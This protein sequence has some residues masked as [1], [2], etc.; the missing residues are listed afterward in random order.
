MT[1][2]HLTTIQKSE[3]DRASEGT[4]LRTDGPDA[5]L[6]L[7]ILLSACNGLPSTGEE[8]GQILTSRDEVSTES[9]SSIQGQRQGN[10]MSTPADGCPLREETSEAVTS[11]I[12]GE[13]LHH[14]TNRSEGSLPALPILRDVPGNRSS[15]DE[16]RPV[17]KAAGRALMSLPRPEREFAASQGA[18]V[19]TDGEQHYIIQRGKFTPRGPVLSPKQF[20]PTT[21][22]PPRAAQEA[23]TPAQRPREVKCLVF[24]DFIRSKS[25][26]LHQTEIPTLETR[27]PGQI[28]AS[29][30]EGREFQL[31]PMLQPSIFTSREGEAVR[32]V[33]PSIAVSEETI[34]SSQSARV[35]MAPTQ[36]ISDRAAKSESGDPLL[37]VEG[38]VRSARL[39][40]EEGQVSSV[41][42][43]QPQEGSRVEKSIDGSRVRGSDSRRTSVG[44][45]KVTS[46]EKNDSYGTLASR[47]P[48][49]PTSKQAASR[50]E[51]DTSTDKSTL[52]PRPS[53]EMLR[54]ERENE[55]TRSTDGAAWQTQEKKES[56]I[57]DQR[58]SRPI[59][60]RSSE[61]NVDAEIRHSG[62]DK[63][64]AVKEPDLRMK[65]GAERVSQLKLEI[66]PVTTANKQ[67][68][69]MPHLAFTLKSN[70]LSAGEPEAALSHARGRFTVPSPE[71]SRDIAW[72]LVKGFSLQVE[73]K[74][75]ELRLAL[76]P[77]SLG[78][79]M[80]RVR[81][82]E[83][84]M[85]A[86]IEVNHD[87]TRA[88]VEASLPRL[89]DDLASRGIDVARIDVFAWGQAFSRDSDGQ[90]ATRSRFVSSDKRRQLPNT[91]EPYRSARLMGYSTIEYIM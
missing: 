22:A 13:W 17:S 28:G 16:N 74:T 64:S 68:E 35:P 48:T 7:S 89:R 21:E 72:Q 34:S 41:F 15:R 51:D 76:N 88:A 38:L 69:N 39:S 5:L 85:A 60:S 50:S 57:N 31:P 90:T 65:E 83:G 58:S 79:V 19:P 66:D 32:A 20:P 67:T 56:L 81:M 24:T 75:S 30:H 61:T 42:A 52:S 84:K 27:F 14:L 43:S 6:F 44:S 86:Q 18:L 1:T 40:S 2:L 53:N 29:L 70:A 91:S 63:T 36:K 10:G 8:P 4:T 49:G 73:E 62:L 59:Q 3:I 33:V 87:G 54:V 26:S 55:P 9:S 78:D 46:L 71:L 45:T 80:L 82:D 25:V 23:S 77:P 37:S 12:V 11:E 47:E